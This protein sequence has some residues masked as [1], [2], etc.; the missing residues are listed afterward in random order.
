MT[1]LDEIENN[2]DN[3]L[4]VIYTGNSKSTDS[5]EVCTQEICLFS[6][7]KS[8]L[9]FG[10]VLNHL[11]YSIMHYWRPIYGYF[12]LFSLRS[13]QRSRNTRIMASNQGA[14]WAMGKRLLTHH[15]DSPGS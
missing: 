3:V 10:T 7:S 13:W 15:E 6:A 8:Y 4:Q 2:H 1:R 9:I 11:A 12:H 5:G 14:L